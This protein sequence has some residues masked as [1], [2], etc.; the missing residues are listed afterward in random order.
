MFRKFIAMG[1]FIATIGASAAFA[2]VIDGEE[3]V[4]PTR[5]V[6][7]EDIDDSAL[8]EII[9]NVVPASFDLS[10]IRAGSNSPMAVINQQR[11]SIGDIIGGAEVKAIDRE[12][13]TLQ[14][15]DRERRISLY[16]VSVKTTSLSQ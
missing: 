12:G 11:V 5:P 3:L 15:G 14:I 1:L 7:I 16:D 8:V 9:R 10:F 13:V 2:E 4:D 6:S